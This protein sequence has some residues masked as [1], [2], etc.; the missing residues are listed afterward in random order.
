L[1]ADRFVDMMARS[2]GTICPAL[3]YAGALLG[4]SGGPAGRQWLGWATSLGRMAFTNY[5]T[6]S[7]IFRW[8]FYGY[9]FGLFDRLGAATALSIGIVVYI[10]QVLYSAWW[11][12]RYRYGPVEW[13]WRTLMYGVSPP[14]LLS[15]DSGR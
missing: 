2:L 3:G 6:Q 13:L 9:G 8:I 14:M 1:F 11:L 12:K 7:V 5:L 15:A 4:V 10:C